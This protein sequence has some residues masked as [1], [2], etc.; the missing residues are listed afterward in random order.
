[1][2][3][4]IAEPIA[5]ASNVIADVT[6]SGGA[7]TTM[8]SGAISLA[9][10]EVYNFEAQIK[11][12]VSTAMR[13]LVNGDTVT[14]NYREGIVISSNIHL[15]F[16]GIYCGIAPIGG[17]VVVSGTIREFNGKVLFEF[18]SVIENTANRRISVSAWHITASSLTSFQITGDAASG[19]DN[20]S[21]LLIWKAN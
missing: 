20:G 12:A 3:D 16:S 21:S 6:V 10:G 17:S 7:V 9:V 2:S 11:F 1:M 14:A 4:L 19:I 5:G 18:E 8:T 13:P 15:D